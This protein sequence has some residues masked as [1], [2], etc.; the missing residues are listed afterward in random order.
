MAISLN[1]G[2]NRAKAK[3]ATTALLPSL[4]TIVIADTAILSFEA[5][6]IREAYELTRE[7]WLLADLAATTSGG[8]PLWD[9]KGRVRARLSTPDEAAR[10]VASA[11]A[12]DADGDVKLVYLI[13]LDSGDRANS[14]E[15]SASETG[16]SEAV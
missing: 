16:A 14:I 7:G 3:S 13:T 6:N 4:F 12:R 2:S 5:Q 10:Y 11:N 15:T 1:A 9:R 8:C